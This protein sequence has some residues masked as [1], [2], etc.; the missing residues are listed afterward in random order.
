[1]SCVFG[2][3]C[4]SEKRKQSYDPLKSVNE[5]DILRA[6]GTRVTVGK[7]EVGKVGYQRDIVSVFAYFAP[8]FK[9]F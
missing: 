2:V 7:L 4:F 9:Q 1:M 8:I 6:A 3:Y 5:T